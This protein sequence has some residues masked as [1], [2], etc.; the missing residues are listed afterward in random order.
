[1]TFKHDWVKSKLGHGEAM[2]S[3]CFTTNRE[4]AA[5]GELENCKVAPPEKE[6]F[7]WAAFQRLR[8]KGEGP[9]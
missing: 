5:L 9:Y 8:K 6:E 3:R 1:M 2:C 4:A 7:D